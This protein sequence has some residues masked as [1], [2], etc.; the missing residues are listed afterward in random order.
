MTL[1]MYWPDVVKPVVFVTQE[2]FI[3][4]LLICVLQIISETIKKTLVKEIR[5]ITILS[6]IY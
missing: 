5:A 2:T 4:T 6:D 1:K 3:I